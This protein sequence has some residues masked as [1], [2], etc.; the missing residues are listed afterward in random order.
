VKRLLLTLLLFPSFLEAQSPSIPS[1]KPLI[2]THVTVIDVTGSPAKP[3]MSVMIRNHRIAAIGRTSSVVPPKDSEIVDATGK[4]LIPGL[5]DMHVHTGRKD[6][7]FPLYIANGVTGVRDMGGDIEDPSGELSS[8]SGRYI[9]LSLWRAAIE[10]GSLLGPRLVIAGFLIDGF[11]WPGNIAATNAE[12]GRQAVDVLKKT[13]VDFVKVKSFLSKDT[14]LAIAAEARRQHMVLA[15]HVPDAVRVAEASNAGQKSI[16][17]LTGIAVG[18]SAIERQLI[19]EK[20]QAFAARDRARYASIEPRAAAMFDPTI[21]TALFSRFVTNGTWQV[22][23][24]VELRRNALGDD[25][26]NPG[27]NSPEDEPLWAYLPEPLRDWWSKNRSAA[28]PSGGQELFAS[29]L[30]L[31][32]KMHKSGVLFLAGTDTPNPSILPGFALHDELKL[33]VSAGFSPMEALQTATL[34]PARYLGKEKDLGT[35]E[36]GKLAD[37]VLLDA[38]PLDD[39]SNTRKIRAVIVDGRYLNREALD[40]ML[41]SAQ[42]TAK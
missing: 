13:G 2:L 22:P 39:I 16:E 40:A 1:T 32:E 7:F 24:L 38:N 20:A 41:A 37:L 33:L 23:T 36:T 21:A 15:G 6:I 42:A 9:Q 14:F 19:D 34:N 18:C 35:I 29:E 28:A 4:F 3:D 31:T 25:S 10:E 30:S 5:W 12:E 26:T 17:H 11:K 8:L 27:Q